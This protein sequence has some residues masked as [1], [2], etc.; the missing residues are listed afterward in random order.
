MLGDRRQEDRIPCRIGAV[1]SDGTGE[2]MHLSVTDLSE[3]GAFVPTKDPMR[4]GSR[5]ELSFEHPTTG[6]KIE[7]VARVA[8]RVLARPG[9]NEKSGNG[10]YFEERITRFRDERRAAERQLCNVAAELHAGAHE[11]DGHL[12]DVSE[13]GALL[14]TSE[15]MQVGAVIRLVFPHP[16]NGNPVD[17]W[18]VVVRGPLP[19][20]DGKRGYGVCFDESLTELEE[21][22]GGGWKRN[23]RTGMLSPR[24]PPDGHDLSCVSDADL[25][26]RLMTR[27]VLVAGVARR[28]VLAGKKEL[29]V[30]CGALPGKG[31]EMTLEL[32]RPK[33]SGLGP[34]RITGRVRRA[35]AAA[36]EGWK[37]GFVLKIDRFENPAEAEAYRDF[38]A[39][40]AV[41]A[42]AH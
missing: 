36:V 29:L 21:V 26:R 17:T 18:G 32:D 12:V 1:M 8:R 42:Q 7:V 35:G 30:E 2:R 34:I 11:T 28:L 15:R 6:E 20:P 38:V 41:R 22:G 16:R 14:V 27:R 33:S 13:G 40:L 37:P 24:L 4:P 25:V 39:W 31:Q 10:L 19:A 5:V 23:E 9:R 3:G